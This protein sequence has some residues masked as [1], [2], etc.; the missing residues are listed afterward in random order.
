MFEGQKYMPCIVHKNTRK[1][2][3]NGLKGP[4]S[5]ASCFQKQKGKLLRHHCSPAMWYCRPCNNSTTILFSDLSLNTQ[6]YRW[7]M[8]L[9]QNSPIRFGQGEQKGSLVISPCALF[10]CWKN[11]TLIC[12]Y[13][14]KGNDMEAIR[15]CVHFKPESPSF[16]IAQDVLFTFLIMLLNTLGSACYL[17]TNKRMHKRSCLYNHCKYSICI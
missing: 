17:G 3:L 13:S 11:G 7:R 15:N 1:T 10:F 2:L 5:S 9:K 4:I 16:S 8:T 6:L 12:F 14:Y